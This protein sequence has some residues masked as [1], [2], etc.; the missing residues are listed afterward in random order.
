[1]T[2]RYVYGQDQAVAAFVAS[3]IPHIDPAGFPSKARA[4]GVTDAAG[5]PLAGVVYYDWNVP[6]GTVVMAAAA[7]PGVFWFSRETIRRVF[8]HAF[9]DL[10]CQMVVM[11]VLADDERL[12]GQLALFG[13]A[14]IPFPRCYG[15]DRDGVICTY[16]AEDW[17]ASKY[18]AP[19]T[20][21][22]Q[23]AA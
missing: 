4:I 5:A 20:Q 2:L 19:V 14:F 1:M 10:R 9:H 17:A 23:E 16:T 7:K 8:D 21:R 11:R 22:Q 13:F 6:A 3:L 15:R 12:L 18:N